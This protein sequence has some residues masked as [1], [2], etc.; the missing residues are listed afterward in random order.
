MLLRK[1][2]GAGYL[3]SQHFHCKALRHCT[4]ISPKHKRW[5]PSSSLKGTSKG[6]TLKRMQKYSVK[7]N[8]WPSPKQNK[9]LKKPFQQGAQTTLRLQ[10][11]ALP[12]K[13]PEHL[14]WA[15]L[16]FC[17]A[18]SASSRINSQLSCAHAADL[19]SLLDLQVR[20]PLTGN[21][22]FLLTPQGLIL[23]LYFSFRC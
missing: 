21:I 18:Q 6:C 2:S 4:F 10:G 1:Y 14:L 17:S 13:A 16:S 22:P 19:Q 7:L 23:R 5:H 8:A 12:S 9:L 20:H 15:E 3:G 11:N